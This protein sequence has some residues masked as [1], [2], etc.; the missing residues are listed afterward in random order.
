MIHSGKLRVCYGES[1]F[2]QG[3]TSKDG[4]K[5]NSYVTSCRRVI[6]IENGKP[7]NTKL[8]FEVGLSND[9]MFV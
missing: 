9:D 1:H 4:H 5:F 6:H 8:L 2:L 3:K 7:M